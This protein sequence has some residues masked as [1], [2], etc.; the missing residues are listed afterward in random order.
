MRY[1]DNRHAKLALAGLANTVKILAA[2]QP[3]LERAG[4]AEWVRRMINVEAFRL[5]SLRA[6]AERSIKEGNHGEVAYTAT[7]YEPAPTV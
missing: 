5:E 2:M 4:C 6:E 3:H 7:K 1:F